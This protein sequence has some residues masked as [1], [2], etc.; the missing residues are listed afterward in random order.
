LPIGAQTQRL[1]LEGKCVIEFADHNGSNSKLSREHL[2]NTRAS[3][4]KPR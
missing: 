3:E 2:C 1:L 4:K